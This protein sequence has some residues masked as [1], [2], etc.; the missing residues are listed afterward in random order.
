MGLLGNRDQIGAQAPK[1]L[2]DPISGGP[3][4][5][6]SIVT[7]LAGT[8]KT[9]GECHRQL[10]GIEEMIEVRPPSSSKGAD[11]PEP[12]SL[13]ALTLDLTNTAITLRTRLEALRQALGG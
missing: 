11:G 7:R 8:L 9:L 10:E 13:S 1:S 6:D 4:T 2:S 12:I 3:V 5:R